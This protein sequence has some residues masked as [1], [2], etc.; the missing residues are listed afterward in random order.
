MQELIGQA[1]RG[2][3]NEEH[4]YE[5]KPIKGFSQAD[6]CASYN[7]LSYKLDE[8]MLHYSYDNRPEDAHNLELEV[9]KQLTLRMKQFIPPDFDLVDYDRELLK[10]QLDLETVEV[11]LKRDIKE[12]IDPENPNVPNYVRSVTRCTNEE[13]MFRR[14]QMDLQIIGKE[15]GVE[16][17][18]VNEIYFQISCSKAKLIETL[19]GKSFT[20]QT[21]LDDYGLEKG[22]ESIEYK[23]L[24]KLKGYEEIIRRKKFLSFLIIAITSGTSDAAMMVTKEK[25]P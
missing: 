19:K 3:S 23:Y 15:Y 17:E 10:K 16:D 21:E 18:Q 9:E 6:L 11:I 25:S 12:E 4:K 7:P 8:P 1:L 24:L 22:T 5:F 2:K 20:K 14:L 13:G